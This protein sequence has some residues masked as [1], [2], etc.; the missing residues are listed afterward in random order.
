MSRVERI[1]P[2][3]TYQDIAA[4]HDFLVKGSLAR[5]LPAIGREVREANLRT[6]TKKIQ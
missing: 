1:I 4:A 5:L 3:L 2:V 6:E